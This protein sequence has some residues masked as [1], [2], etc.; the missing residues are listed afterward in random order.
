MEVIDP[1][2]NSLSKFDFDLF[3]PRADDL[4]ELYLNDNNISSLQGWTQMILPNLK[5]LGISNNNLTCSYLARFIRSIILSKIVLLQEPTMLA[6]DDKRRNIQ[7]ITC[8]NPNDSLDEIKIEK[9]EPNQTSMAKDS[10][11]TIEYH[12][13]HNSDSMHVIMY[14]LLFLCSVCSL[15]IIIKC[16][17]FCKAKFHF[18]ETQNVSYARRNNAIAVHHCGLC[19]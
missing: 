19:R 5:L 8:V 10:E 12:H 16:F 7:K 6:H 17:K 13:H 11:K 9:L 1:S 15:F 3:L 2:H 18:T 14:S 4:H